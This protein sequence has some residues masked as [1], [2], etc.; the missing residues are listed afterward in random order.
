[1]R[2]TVWQITMNGN[3][4]EQRARIIKFYYQCSVRETIR[5]LRD[6]YHEKRT[7][8][9]YYAQQRRSQRTFR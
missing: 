1:M 6:F 4:V 5:A 3:S 7:S 2:C 9:H 8:V